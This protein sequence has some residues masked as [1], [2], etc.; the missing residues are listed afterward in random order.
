MTVNGDLTVI[1]TT[2]QNNQSTL[3]V[4]ATEIVIND[5][6]SGAPALDGHIKIDRGTGTDVSLK[7]NEGSD[8]WQF[9]ND[10]TTYY[11]LPTGTNDLTNNA[12]FLT[13]YTE[14]DPVFSASSC[15]WYWI[16]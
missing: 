3:N 13:S 6:Q 15:I 11:N 5:G 8:R 2:T 14:T 9:T 12:G 4:A 1:G 16:I 10:G 7:W